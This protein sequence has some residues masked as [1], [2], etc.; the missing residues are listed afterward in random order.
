M[1]SYRKAKENTLVSLASARHE[2]R[3]WNEETINDILDLKNFFIAA[4][5]WNHILALYFKFIWA[6]ILYLSHD[7]E[8]K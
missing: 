7:C 4:K 2:T 1:H 8:Y 6:L 5:S 3:C